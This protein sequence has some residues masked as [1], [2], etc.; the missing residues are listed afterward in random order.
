MSRCCHPSHPHARAVR[1]YRLA[2]TPASYPP[3]ATRWPFASIQG[4]FL[5]VIIENA[6]TPAP[7]RAR[8]E[9]LGWLG[10]ADHDLNRRAVARRH[11]S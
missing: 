10:G 5:M 7:A 2:T 6:E 8:R 9:W 11:R 1:H 3:S 4:P